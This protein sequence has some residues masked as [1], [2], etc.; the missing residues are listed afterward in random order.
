M[1]KYHKMPH[2]IATQ[3]NIG[4]CW[5][6]GEVTL[7]PN[8]HAE[9]SGHIELKYMAFRYETTCFKCESVSRI[10]YSFLSKQSLTSVRKTAAFLSLNRVSEPS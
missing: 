5:P 6:H 4:H 3:I 10:D 1:I 7:F 9:T 8:I 2:N